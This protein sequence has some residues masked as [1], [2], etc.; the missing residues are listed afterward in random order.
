MTKSLYSL[1]FWELQL[2]IGMT[3]FQRTFGPTVRC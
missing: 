3:S 1:Y 2:Q